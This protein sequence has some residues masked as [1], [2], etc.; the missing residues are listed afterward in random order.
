[1]GMLLL[2][3]SWLNLLTFGTSINTSLYYMKK[4]L[5]YPLLALASLTAFAVQVPIGHDISASSA[6]AT[7]TKPSTL[8]KVGV[9]PK[10]I[11]HVTTDLSKPAKVATK[12]VIHPTGRT[13][14]TPA[15]PKK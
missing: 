9:P 14:S 10:V 4:F 5:I 8:P 13:A 1:M 2:V 3:I 12:P 7:G 15:D 6:K 11:S